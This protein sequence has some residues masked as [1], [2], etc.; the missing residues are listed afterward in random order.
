MRKDSL[1]VFI[2]KIEKE[3]QD[4]QSMLSYF[5][6]GI[7]LKVLGDRLWGIDNGL[8]QKC[9]NLCHDILENRNGNKS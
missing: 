3:I 8:A 4:G 5:Q 2:D 9:N 6:L 7:T 1:T